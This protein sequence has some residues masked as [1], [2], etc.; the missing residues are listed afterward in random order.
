MVACLCSPCDVERSIFCFGVKAQRGVATVDLSFQLMLNVVQRADPQVRAKEDD[1]RPFGLSIRKLLI[2]E[3]VGVVLNKDHIL[4]PKSALRGWS[5]EFFMEAFKLFDIGIWCYADARTTLK[6][7][8]SIFDEETVKKLRFVKS[9][10]HIRQKDLC[11]FRVHQLTL[12]PKIVP[13]KSLALIWAEIP[14]YNESNTVLIDCRSYHG[15][16]NPSYTLLSV[17]ILEFGTND[18][19]LKDYLWPCLSMLA[20]ACNTRLFLSVSE[21]RWSRQAVQD[22]LKSYN[23]VIYE[24]LEKHCSQM[25]GTSRKIVPIFSALQWS[26]YE[27]SPTYKQKVISVLQRLKEGNIEKLKNRSCFE[28]FRQL[29]G[30]WDKKYGESRFSNRVRFLRECIRLLD[31]TDRFSL[32]VPKDSCKALPGD[33]LGMSCYNKLCKRDHHWAGYQISIRSR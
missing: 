26:I 23:S 15:W 24:F 33:S 2:F 12:D 18:M 19:F 28:P 1:S 11:T 22:E 17:P 3:L 14:T 30:H 6:I 5:I 25:K 32:D 20:T 4:G 9:S 31:E 21:P 16:T 8:R 27:M 29:K 7:V 13:F 10:L